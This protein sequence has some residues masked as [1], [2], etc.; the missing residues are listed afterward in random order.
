MPQLLSLPLYGILPGRNFTSLYHP[1]RV[2]LNVLEGDYIEEHVFFAGLQTFRLQQKGDIAVSDAAATV[3]LFVKSDPSSVNLPFAYEKVET[4]DFQSLS[5]LQVRDDL[6]YLAMG[7]P[8]VVTVFR[9]RQS[10]FSDGTLDF[11]LEVKEELESGLGTESWFGWSVK[12]HLL[13]KDGAGD[14]PA[15]PVLFVGA[16]QWGVG[17][18]K[19]FTVAPTEDASRD[20]QTLSPPMDIPDVVPQAFGYSIGAMEN[21]VMV[22]APKT[23]EDKGAVFFYTWNT[24]SGQYELKKAAFVGVNPT[25]NTIN[26]VEVHE[27]AG[28]IA[29][30]GAALIPAQFGAEIGAFVYD[31]MINPVYHPDVASDHA[32]YRW[33]ASESSKRNRYLYVVGYHADHTKTILYL[34]NK[35]DDGTFTQVSSE[36]PSDP[37]VPQVFDKEL[38]SFFTFYV[39]TVWEVYLSGVVNLSR[40]YYFTEAQ[41]RVRAEEEKSQHPIFSTFHL[42]SLGALNSAGEMEYYTLPLDPKVGAGEDDYL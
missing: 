1:A 7:Y 21:N 10:D 25:I 39:Q 32:D 4:E 27:M 16:P 38:G 41:A 36:D 26:G 11:Q 35:R 15:E 22:G 14:N 29:H 18:V 34:F 24:T 28:T 5:A 19:V 3:N 6:F 12:L 31:S 9:A 13:D 37:P 2:D 8:S 20:L 23:N 30:S 33:I 17:I 42:Y 40:W